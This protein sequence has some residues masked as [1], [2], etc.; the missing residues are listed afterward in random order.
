MKIG[1][2]LV[3]DVGVGRFS[4]SNGV[5]FSDSSVPN[6]RSGDLLREDGVETSAVDCWLSKFSKN[7]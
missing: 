6:T 3:A 4:G 7:A 2:F 1:S 5:A